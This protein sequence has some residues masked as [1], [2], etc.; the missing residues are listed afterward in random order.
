MSSCHSARVRRP[1]RLRSSAVNLRGRPVVHRTGGAEILELAGLRLAHRVAQLVAR[2]HAVAVPVVD[3]ERLRAAAPFGAGDLAVAVGVHLGE[4]LTGCCV[5]AWLAGCCAGCGSAAARDVSAAASTAMRASNVVGRAMDAP[6]PWKVQQTCQAG[7]ANAG[8]SPRRAVTHTGQPT[9]HLS[10]R[11][12]HFSYPFHTL[13]TSGRYIVVS[14]AGARR[15]AANRANGE[16]P[17]GTT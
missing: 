10:G 9:A 4:A 3:A 15:R 5:G 11:P 2:E 17:R 7:G 8:A 14:W 1:S 6:L 13:P 12:R 16:L